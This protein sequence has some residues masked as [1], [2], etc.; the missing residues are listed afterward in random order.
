MA[1]AQGKSQTV[2][3]AATPP[4][5]TAGAAGGAPATDKKKRD[6]LTPAQSRAATIERVRKGVGK[7]VAQLQGAEIRRT[8]KL[9][10]NAALVAAYE[11]FDAELVKIGTP[12]EVAPPATA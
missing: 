11:A 10:G 3:P 6:R 5:S 1:T 7:A 4:G 2:P 12:V 9:S 8:G